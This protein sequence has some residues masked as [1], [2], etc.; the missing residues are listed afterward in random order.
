MDWKGVETVIIKASG[1]FF[2]PPRLIF[3]ACHD[4]KWGLFDVIHLSNNGGT[5]TGTAANT[6]GIPTHAFI[7]DKS[8]FFIII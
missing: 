7:Q 6:V 8:E 4:E 2:F 1:S 5:L 3:K